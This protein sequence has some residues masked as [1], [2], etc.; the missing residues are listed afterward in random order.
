MKTPSCCFPLLSF[1]P[2]GS[3]SASNL[4]FATS[5]YDNEISLLSCCF[6]LLTCLSEGH[7]APSCHCGA[8]LAEATP[9]HSWAAAA[10]SFPHSSTKVFCQRFFFFWGSVSPPCLRATD[11]V[12]DGHVPQQAGPSSL[13]REWGSLGTLSV[14]P[15]P[16]APGALRPAPI[17]TRVRGSALSLA[18]S[19]IWVSV[20]ARIF[21]IAGKQRKLSDGN[22]HED[23]KN[24]WNW[25]I[26]VVCILGSTCDIVIHLHRM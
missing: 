24:F 18:V 25:Y 3:I 6:W 15:Q 22:I 8:S 1:L 13:S 11:L 7:P 9:T 5:I 23:N 2:R 12:K 14:T 19:C 17:L 16:S 4:I 26:L 20:L 10:A 21:C